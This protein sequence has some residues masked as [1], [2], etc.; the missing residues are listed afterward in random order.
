MNSRNLVRMF[1]RTLLLGAGSTLVTSFFVKAP[2][3]MEYLDPVN[4]FQLLGVLIF[5]VGL[6]LVFSLV[7]QMGFFAYLTVNQLALGMLRRFWVPLQALLVLFT[8]F[9]LVYFRYN[10]SDGQT[11]IFVYIATAVFL[12][13]YGW[14]VSAK[15]AKETNRNAFIPALFFMVVVTSIEWV[16][17]LRTSGSD[18]AWLMIVPLLLCNTYQLLILHKL[19]DQTKKEQS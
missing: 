2:T 13:V 5:F 7:S 18:Y 10:A 14:I 3:Y 11:S 1:L 4:L 19:N 12:F 17:G 9:D 8:I 16:P 15:K 6:G